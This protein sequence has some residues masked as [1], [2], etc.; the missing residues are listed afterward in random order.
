[1]VL[2]LDNACGSPV[3]NLN[4]D[5]AFVRLEVLVMV[6]PVSFDWNEKWPNQSLPSWSSDVPPS[7]LAAHRLLLS[8]VT[9]IDQTTRYAS[10]VGGDP[11]GV[12]RR[13][14]A[15]LTAPTA[16]MSEAIEDMLGRVVVAWRGRTSALRSKGHV[17]NDRCRHCGVRLNSISSRA[18]LIAKRKSASSA[19]AASSRAPVVAL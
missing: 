19:R 12:T 17:A 3:A 11:D 2:S 4:M 7:L 14:T 13:R 5:L 9:G 6:K 10:S 18:R 16:G 1:M 8:V 15:K